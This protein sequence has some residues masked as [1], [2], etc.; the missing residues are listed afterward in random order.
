MCFSGNLHVGS[1]VKYQKQH[2]ANPSHGRDGG[3]IFYITQNKVPLQPCNRITI[4]SAGVYKVC[5]CAKHFLFPSR[6]FLPDYSF[7]PLPSPP[8]R[9]LLL[10]FFH[11]ENK[12]WQRDKREF[13]LCVLNE[14][15]RFLL[16]K[17][18]G[19]LRCTLFECRLIDSAHTYV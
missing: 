3:Q 13:Y 4:P 10:A 12:K 8:P 18:S 7:L 15:V 6:S 17:S 14:F 1:V 5:K 2:P 19:A 16:L 9:Q 11:W